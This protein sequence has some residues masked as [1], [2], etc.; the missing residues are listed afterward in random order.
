MKTPIPATGRAAASAA[1]EAFGGDLH[2]GKPVIRRH[3]AS[4]GRGNIDVLTCLE[5][6]VPGQACY[7]TLGL[8]WVPNFLDDQDVRVE[9]GGVA[10]IA[11]QPE[12][13]F[14][15]LLAD[16]AFQVLN[17]GWLA[18]PGVIFPD[19]VRNRQ[20]SRTMEH[21][22]W[23]PPFPWPQ[24]GSVAVGDGLDVHWLMAVPIS[25]S[26][27]QFVLKHG[28]DEFESLMAKHDVEYWNL[29]RLAAA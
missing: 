9:L 19:L 17:D 7:S 29:G 27:R 16:A 5:R 11:D 26:E 13:G 22:I 18:A 10:S 23:A 20:L 28:F 24:L 25:E 6:P 1:I 14:A 2:G 3:P 21:V 4:D 12:I 8:L 15:Y